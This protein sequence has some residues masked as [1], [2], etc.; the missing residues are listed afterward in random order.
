MQLNSGYTLCAYWSSAKYAVF[1]KRK[2]HSVFKI[3]SF[4]HAQHDLKIVQNLDSFRR[5]DSGRCWT[6]RVWW[7]H[8]NAG[9]DGGCGSSSCAGRDTGSNACAY[10]STRRYASTSTRR[11]A[12]TSTSTSAGSCSRTRTRSRRYACPRSSRC[13]AHQL[14]GTVP[15]LDRCLGELLCTCGGDCG[16]RISR[17]DEHGSRQYWHGKLCMHRNRLGRTDRSDLHGDSRCLH[18]GHQ[19]VLIS[20]FV[21]RPLANIYWLFKGVSK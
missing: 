8:Y 17:V 18:A 5:D 6:C 13:S 20:R 1:A 21:N 10:A 11:Y 9:H 14:R 7:R 3:R 12:S 2:L 4:S 16:W 15:H 19:R